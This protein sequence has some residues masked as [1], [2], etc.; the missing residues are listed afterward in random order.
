ME[1]VVWGL[2]TYR[3]ARRSRAACILLSFLFA[4]E[5]HILAMMIR[6]MYIERETNN[7]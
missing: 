1:L 7:K 3:R 6:D 5:D 4:C 2:V